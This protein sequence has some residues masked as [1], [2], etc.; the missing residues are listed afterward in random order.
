MA[1]S[2]LMRFIMV[3]MSSNCF[4]SRFTSCTLEPEPAAMRFLRDALMMSGVRRSALV[5]D[6]MMA[7]CRFRI[8]RSGSLPPI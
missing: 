6:E 1:P 3:D 4:S 8:D 5:M 7:P 2:L